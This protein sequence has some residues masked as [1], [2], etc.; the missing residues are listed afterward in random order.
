MNKFEYFTNP[1]LYANLTKRKR[2]CAI[3][4]VIEIC[5]DSSNFH[6]ND[7]YGSICQEC[8]RN[9]KIKDLGLST[10]GYAEVNQDQLTGSADEIAR[11]IFKIKY[12]TPELPTWQDT[13][14]PIMKGDFCIF[15]K[16]S[17]KMDYPGGPAELH[18]YI[19]DNYRYDDTAEY[20]W[21]LIPDFEQDNTTETDSDTR[22]YLFTFNGGKLVI[23]DRS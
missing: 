13:I 21:D 11:K 20:L 19:P 1:L 4:E 15:E 6:G 18:S 9:G 22:F 2:P 5:F 14:W 16:V 3:C 8:L 23:F 10:N 12:C 17:S 7:F